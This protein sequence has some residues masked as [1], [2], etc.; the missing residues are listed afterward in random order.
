MKAQEAYKLLFREYPDV[1][2]VEQMCRM[3]GGINVKTGYRLL[4]DRKIKSIMIGRQY[5]IPKIYIFEYLE[6]VGSPDANG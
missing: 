5:R 3:L 6:I 1:V 2:D 4:K